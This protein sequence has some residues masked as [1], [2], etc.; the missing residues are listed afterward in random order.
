VYGKKPAW[1]ADSPTPRAVSRP[2]PIRRQDLSI[3][4]YTTPVLYPLSLEDETG[5][6]RFLTLEEAAYR[7]ASFLD[8]RLIAEPALADWRPW[9]EVERAAAPLAV[10]CD[11]IFH[12]GHVG[13]TLISRLLGRCAGVFSLRET[14][15]LRT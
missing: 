9:P 13:S 11:F 12:I 7:D 14:A 10:S 2:S 5:A 8:E 4:D 3:D 1:T 6:V 15:V